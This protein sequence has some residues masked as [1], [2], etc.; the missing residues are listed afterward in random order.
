MSVASAWDGMDTCEIF[1]VYYGIPNHD[2]NDIY[3]CGE[4]NHFYVVVKGTY[5]HIDITATHI[6]F[7]VRDNGYCLFNALALYYYIQK[8][9]TNP[10]SKDDLTCLQEVEG[11]DYVLI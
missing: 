2:I 8:I 4:N 10:I 7:N 1:P 11:K 5:L 6:K 3:I 9:R